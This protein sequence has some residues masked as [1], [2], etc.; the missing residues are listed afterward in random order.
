MSSAALVICSR[1][2]GQLLRWNCRQLAGDDGR[3][4]GATGATFPARQSVCSDAE[5]R[6]P[7]QPDGSHPYFAESID[8]WVAPFIMAP[9]NTKNIHRSNFLLGGAYGRDFQ[10]DEMLV[11]GTGEVARAAAEALRGR[12]AYEISSPLNPGEGPDLAARQKGFYDILFSGQG[13]GREG[14][15]LAVNGDQD[16][17]YGSTSKMITQAALC[18]LENSEGAG[19]VWTPA[20]L[21]GDALVGRLQA[22]VGVTFN[23]IN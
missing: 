5:F 21:L 3:R 15:Q 11:T 9:I 7:E 10:Y 14:L 13:G 2:E 22:N 23:L 6:G 17:G 4:C 18:L 20:A 19:G 8:A 1:Y 16:P 12:K